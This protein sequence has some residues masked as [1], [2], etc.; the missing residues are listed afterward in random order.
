MLNDRKH[1]QIPSPPPSLIKAAG[2]DIVKKKPP[3]PQ[4]YLQE[5]SLQVQRSIL[6]EAENFQLSVETSGSYSE[7]NYVPKASSLPSGSVLMLWLE[8]LLNFSNQLSPATFNHANSS[9]LQCSSR[10]S[11]KRLAG[12]SKARETGICA[13]TTKFW[14]LWARK[15]ISPNRC[16]S[17]VSW[18]E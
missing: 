2:F 1:C 7:P 6:R 17:Q 16:F 11:S 8:N 9:C 4:Q 13:G 3:K 12:W 18:E 5:F 15:C 10:L 14:W